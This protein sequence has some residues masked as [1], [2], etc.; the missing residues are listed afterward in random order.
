[1][2]VRRHRRKFF[3]PAQFALGFLTH[4]VRQIGFG[5]T[6][7]QLRGLR[8]FAAFVFAQL[9]LDR[10]HLLTQNVIAL[11]FVHLGL[12]FAGDLRTQPDDLDF[13]REKIVREMHQVVD[14]VRFEHLLF[15]L[16]PQAE[17]RTEKVSQPN[18]I[19]RA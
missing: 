15:F 11:G 3:H 6:L 2:I 13:V 8:L 18:R 10:L 12:R 1:M 9:F 16:N 19:V 4:L 7:A 5:E 14:S 17:N